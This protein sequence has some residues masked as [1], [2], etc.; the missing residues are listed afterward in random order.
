MVL[1]GF[2]DAK[3]IFNTFIIIIQN[4]YQAAFD[5][6]KTVSKTFHLCSIYAFEVNFT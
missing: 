2:E 6:K 1:K 4:K 5:L 3:I